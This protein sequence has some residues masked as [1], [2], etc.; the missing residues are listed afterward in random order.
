M[1]TKQP[2]YEHIMSSAVDGKLP[3][4]FSL[5]DYD[6]SGHPIR[7]ADGA[8][9]G[10][11]V[12]HMGRPTLPDGIVQTIARALETACAGDYEAASTSLSAL[13]SEHRAIVLIDQIQQAVLEIAPRVDANALFAYATYLL[14]TSTNKELVKTGLSI[15]ELFNEPDDKLKHLIRT[16]GLCDEFTIFSAWNARTWSNG[17]EE[18]FS[19]AKGTD[20]WG[21]IH[22]IEMLEP[23]T[24]EIRE[25]LLLE[26]V[27]NEVVPAY[28]AL[29]CY[30]KAGVH[31][32]L[33]GTMTHEEFSGATSIVRALLD[34]GPVPGVSALEDPQSELSRYLAQAAKQQLDL[35]DC[36][37]INAIADYAEGEGWKSLVAE[38][39]ALLETDAVRLLVEEELA[40]GRGMNLA[41]QLGI[42]YKDALLNA[43][44]EDFDNLYS[45]CSWLMDDPKYLDALLEL[46][47]EKVPLD[48]IEDDPR[49]EIGLGKEFGTYTKL[50]ML[51]QALR[52]RM[53]AGLDY[54]LRTLT[55]PTVRNRTLSHR[56]LRC[57]VSDEGRPLSEVSPEAY[58]RLL[59]AYEKEPREDLREAMKPLID[60]ETVF[61]EDKL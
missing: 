1:T 56:V 31:E 33:A 20:G 45:Q 60:G 4:G 50:D 40:S 3:D 34:E 59:Y 49:D 36:E 39:D 25:W 18:V 10:I 24:E 38:C 47:R 9:D 8:M 30:T 5:A 37:C 54:L 23:E 57:W 29:T 53:P 55:S 19:L 6:E 7:M 35:G 44:R 13:L 27:H 12:Y 26:G 17:N 42:P 28:S 16:F 32:R 11:V 51:I 61:S 46:Y 14:F 52:H 43:M 2:I 58:E 41:R 48:T 15:L 22:T 21:R